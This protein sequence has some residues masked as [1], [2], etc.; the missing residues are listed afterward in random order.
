MS[1]GIRVCAGCVRYWCLACGWNKAVGVYVGLTVVACARCETPRYV[2]RRH[3]VHTR[4]NECPLAKAQ[5]MWCERVRALR[6]L[7]HVEGEGWE[8]VGEQRC[9]AVV[10]AS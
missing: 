8:C 1:D 2:E 7:R 4:W 3:V 9:T 10:K 5:C 6:W